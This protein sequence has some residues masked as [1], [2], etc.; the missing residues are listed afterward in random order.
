MFKLLVLPKLHSEKINNKSYWIKYFQFIEKYSKHFDYRFGFYAE[1]LHFKG[2]WEKYKKM[3][4]LSYSVGANLYASNIFTVLHQ[5]KK[6]NMNKEFY[7]LEDR[8]IVPEY[9]DAK[10][11]IS[12]NRTISAE[13]DMHLIRIPR[14]NVFM[15]QEGKLIQVPYDEV[16]QFNKDKVVMLCKVYGINWKKLKKSI[17]KFNL[18][19]LFAYPNNYLS[20]QR[21]LQ[22]QSVLDTV[23][24]PVI[25]KIIKIVETSKSPKEIMESTRVLCQL[26]GTLNRLG[27]V[28]DGLKTKVQEARSRYGPINE[29]DQIVE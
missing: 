25:D 10:N 13:F 11:I 8:L 4:R 5:S 28:D 9:F 16:R 23:F 6:F 3:L 14:K 7:L 29:I 15:L 18:F 20:W 2:F 12:K 19:Q 1:P 26:M 21:N 24:N 22:D 27:G 17:F